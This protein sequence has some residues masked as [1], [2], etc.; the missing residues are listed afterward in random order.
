MNQYLTT[1][2]ISF[3]YINASLPV[4]AQTTV[5]PQAENVAPSSQPSIKLL[6]SLNA[7]SPIDAADLSRDGKTLVTSSR[8]KLQVWNLATG[9]SKTFALLDDNYATIKSIAISPDLQTVVTKSSGLDINSENTTPSGCQSNSGSGTFSWGCSFGG[10]SSSSIK[11]TS[12]YAIQ[13]WDLSTGKQSGILERSESSSRNFP[14]SFSSSSASNGDD[15]LKFSA[16]GNLLVSSNNNKP[17]FWNVKTGKVIK[18]IDR[19]RFGEILCKHCLAIDTTDGIKVFSTFNFATQEIDSKKEPIALSF[20]DRDRRDERDRIFKEFSESMTTAFSPDGKSIAVSNRGDLQVWQSTTGDRLH[21]LPDRLDSSYT[22]LAFSPDSQVIAGAKSDG[23]IQLWDLKNGKEIGK[24][25]AQN[26]GE[27]LFLGFA[28]DGK[29]LVSIGSKGTIQLWETKLNPHNLP[30]S[31]AQNDRTSL[32][33]QGSANEL[34]TKEANTYNNRGFL[35]SLAN[36]ISGALADY[37]RAI[38]L[39]RGSANELNPKLAS[40][41]K[42]RGDLKEK[43]VNDLSGAL[44]DYS[45]AIEFNSKLGIELNSK[46]AGKYKSR[47]DL[48]FFNLNDREGALADYSK[49]IL[50]QRGSANE[51]NPL[52]AW[53]YKNRADLKFFT[54][55]D[56]AGALTDYRKAIELNTQYAEAH[57]NLANLKQYLSKKSTSTKITGADRQKRSTSSK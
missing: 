25:I 30:G 18:G 17:K 15:L 3:C 28:L 16:D 22:Y 27:N 41:Y 39:Q 51:L 13:I 35:K 57:N 54:F 53:S 46:L 6:Q 23:T 8:G 4:I 47:A 40:A 31:L 9:A 2:L 42:N 5:A 44:A 43:N 37:N 21:R 38:L 52:D 1:L 19:E 11:S 48:K 12:G 55:D 29:T 33:Y 24:T 14:F 20:P 32:P 49:A 7:K 36:D 26:E 50:L 34:N 56:S 10:Y 45:K